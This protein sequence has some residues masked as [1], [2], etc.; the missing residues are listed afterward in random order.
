MAF[1]FRF[2]CCIIFNRGAKKM[3]KLNL[4]QL[5]LKN[6]NIKEKE[7]IKL[8]A[9]E[10]LGTECECS[11]VFTLQTVFDGHHASKCECSSIWNILGNMAVP[12]E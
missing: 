8:K 3:N 1:D 6:E 9:G 11:S 7:M 12:L 2:F 4:A 10:S 5:N